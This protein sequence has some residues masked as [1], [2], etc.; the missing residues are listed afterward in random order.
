MHKAGYCAC[1]YDTYAKHA[2]TRSET[3]DQDEE[4]FEVLDRTDFDCIN[5]QRR[6]RKRRRTDC[7]RDADH[8]GDMDKGYFTTGVVV[9]L[10]GAPME[11][12]ETNGCVGVYSGIGVCSIVESVPNRSLP[13]EKNLLKT[14]SSEQ[15]AATVVFEDHTGAVPTSRSNKN[16]PRTK[17]IDIKFHHAR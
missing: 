3:D 2:K 8:A 17:H 9:S 4:G 6:H 14:I 7:V 10:A 11:V 5:L 16:T 13:Q 15:S 12:G 1:S